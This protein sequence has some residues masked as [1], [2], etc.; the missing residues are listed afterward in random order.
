MKKTELLSPAGNF[1]KMTYA[2][3]YGA[4]AVYL[5]GND[6]GMRAAADNFTVEQIYSAVKYA[7]ERGVKIYVTVNTMPRTGEY[8][9]LAEYLDSLKGSGADALIVADLGVIEL[10]KQHLPDM[11][12]H[13]STQASIVSAAACEAY[14]KLGASRVVLARELSL[15]EIREIRNTVSKELELEAFIHGSMCM[16]YSGLCLLSEYFT[17]RD[18]NRGQ[19]TQPC[20]WNYKLYTY[21]AEEAQHSGERIPIEQDEYGTFM[22]SSRDMCMIEHMAE[23]IDAGIDS[24]KIEGRMKS[25]FYTAVTTNSYRI[26]ISDALAGRSFNAALMREVE[27]VSHR[28][29]STGHYFKNAGVCTQGGYI[30]DKAFLATAD[31]EGWFL[32]RNKL[33]LGD[34][35][36]IISPGKTGR[37]FRIESIINEKGE[38]ITSTPHPL[39]KFKV[40]TPFEAAEGDILRGSGED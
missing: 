13:V 34:T 22:M 6:F 14:H 10:V 2:V 40:N 25:A 26:A 23:L 35:V 9:K 27:S 7:H 4:D 29:Y 37:K 32:Q 20:R 1:E 38:P 11:D 31:S 18:A 12:I 15:E 30:R 8:K 28:E 33:S 36:E 3:R 21:E 39:M 16:S 5:A 24:F 17:G 19:C